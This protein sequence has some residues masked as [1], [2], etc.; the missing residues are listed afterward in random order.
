MLRVLHSDAKAK[1]TVS[2]CPDLE[3]K[4][5][6]AVKLL[7]E[8]G[9]NAI[10]LDLHTAHKGSGD[11]AVIY[12]LAGGSAQADE[13][14]TSIPLPTLTPQQTEVLKS[15]GE[16]KPNKRIAYE[17]GITETTV[18][19]HVTNIYRKLGVRNRSEAILLIQ[20]LHTA[21]QSGPLTREQI[22]AV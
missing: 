10:F 8:C 18:K 12:R 13:E 22:L 2:R 15:I 17:L 4:L 6:L 19:A 9:F 21:G 11:R 14:R 7:Q 3:S 1:D 5:A 16:A 20:A